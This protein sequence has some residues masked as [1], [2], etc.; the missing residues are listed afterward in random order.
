LDVVDG[1]AVTGGQNE[2]LVDG[3]TIKVPMPCKIAKL[4]VKVG[5][6]VEKGAIVAVTETMKMEVVERSRFPP[7]DLVCLAIAPSREKGQGYSN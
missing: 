2:D 7:F 3:K 4:L 6:V 5:D 1:L